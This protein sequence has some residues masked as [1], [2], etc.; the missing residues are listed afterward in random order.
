MSVQ[1]CLAVCMALTLSGRLIPGA[2]EAPPPAIHV[3]EGF[4]V[5]CVAA[6]PLV[7]HPMLACFD[8]RGRLFVCES[9]GTNR[10]ASELLADPQDKI[11]VLDDDNGDGVFDKSTV[12]ADKLVFPQGCLWYRGALYTC[13]SPYLWKLDDTDND[14]VCDK[15]TVLVKSFGF[16][17]NAADIHGPFLSPDG[18]LYWCDGRHGHEIRDLGEGEFGG[19]DN[20]VAIP[21]KPEP[22]L[23]NPEGSLLTKGKAARI[24]SC[25][26]DG[27]EV[28][29]LC[30]GG[31]DNP[32]EVDF[33]ETGECLGSVNLFYGQPRGDCLVHWVEGGVY[34]RFDQQDC[35]AEFKSTGELLREVHNYGHV[36]V[37]GMARYRSDQF[38]GADP[39]SPPTAVGGTLTDRAHFFVTEFNTHKVVHTILERD[40][41]TFRHVETTDFFVSD[42]PD[43]HPTDVL[44]DADGS[45]LV[46]DTGGWFRIGCPTSQIAKPEIGGAIYR[47]RRDGAHQ[48]DDPRGARLDFAAM[49]PAD[50]LPYLSDSRPWVRE[51]AIESLAQPR[52]EQQ[53]GAEVLLRQEKTHPLSTGRVGLAHALARGSD[54]MGFA[55]LE[56]LLKDADLRVRL[57]A[58]TVFGSRARDLLLYE[59]VHLLEDG[60][61]CEQRAT[62]A[63]VMHRIR[64]GIDV[65]DPGWVRPIIV[66]AL[67]EAVR[68]RPGDRIRDH[69]AIHAL[70][71]TAAT[72]E[73]TQ[74]LNDP[75]TGVRRASLIALDQMDGGNLTREQVVPLLDTADQDLQQTVLDV[76][77]GREGWE[78][79]TFALLRTWAFDPELTAERESMLR[80]FLTARAGEPEVQSLISAAM[81]DPNLPRPTRRVLLDVMARAGIDEFPQEWSQA[82]GALLANADSEVRLLAIR[83]IGSRRIDAFDERLLEL[84]L[85]EMELPTVR[86]EA[87]AAVSSRLTNV[88]APLFDVLHKQLIDPNATIIDRLRIAGA[89]AKAPLNDEQLSVVA[90]ALEQIG[91]S[92]APALLPAFERSSSV[93]VGRLLVRT[94]TPM[95]ASLSISAGEL[96]RLLGHYSDSVRAEAAPL[97]A[98][99][100]EQAA[101][102]AAKLD[103]LASGVDVGV[104]ARGR[105][106]FFSRKAGCGSCHRIGSDGAPVGPDLSKIGTIRQPR[107]LLESIVFPSVSFARGYE[108]YA[109][110]TSD[111]RVVNGVI[112]RETSDEIV[113]R[114]TDLSEVRVRRKEIDAMQQSRTSIMPQGLETRLSAGELRDLLAYL[115]SL[116]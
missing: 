76:I 81:L 54:A 86:N 78:S 15:R 105:D 110:V 44:E 25:K 61:P 34:P 66:R 64:R 59:V 91:P 94:L 14:G 75:N 60:S 68:R 108:P 24:F 92:V 103:A 10:R 47:I 99:F 83:V 28:Q 50:V 26:P 13:S 116:R 67:M 36:A 46:I 107:D 8:D 73:V 9:A 38:F 113:L 93:D 30:G 111:G 87:F 20:A 89:L 112:S 48:I 56:V 27:S 109:V 70:F 11:L 95:G 82:L 42:N 97:L 3:P 96:E 101:Q 51:A 57:C 72:D 31:M 6:A 40:G 39:Q 100:H 32:V 114:L 52:G 88:P 55:P 45:L 22:G 79:D 23:P 74:Y 19:E 17:G 53:P 62:A 115:Q 49:E 77:S 2:D 58:V 5:E 29:V 102:R 43:C 18:R 41:A 71:E 33:W 69:A 80:G 85:S 21:P 98:A 84:A 37:S 65:P 4:T 63:A 106:V 7:Q 35:I 1:K 104:P 12:F 90:G 16:S